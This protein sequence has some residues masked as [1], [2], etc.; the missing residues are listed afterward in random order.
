MQRQWWWWRR[1]GELE[2]D[3]ATIQVGGRGLARD[4]G[5]YPLVLITI[6]NVPKQTLLLYIM[7][8]GVWK[9]KGLQ[10]IWVYKN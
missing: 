5:G 7:Y 2:D 3:E 1:G 9:V 4:A 8:T 6:N 10:V